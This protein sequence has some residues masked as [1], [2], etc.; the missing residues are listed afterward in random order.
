MVSRFRIFAIIAIVILFSGNVIANSEPEQ[1]DIDSFLNGL[2]GGDRTLYEDKLVKNQPADRFVENVELQ[3]LNKITGKS[4]RIKTKVGKSSIF[5]RLEIL[6]LKC[7]KSYPEENPENKL[8]L[9]V[10]ETNSKSEKKKVIFYG[11]IF[12]SSPSISG[13]EHSLYD[14][15]LEDCHNDRV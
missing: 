15:K 6:P 1:K 7:W 5:E 10:Y 14:L 4:F 11:W 2:D 8:L 12:S 13:L 9:K 3:I